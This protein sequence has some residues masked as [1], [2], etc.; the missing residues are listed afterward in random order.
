MKTYVRSTHSEYS[1]Q[2][3]FRQLLLII[4]YI[5]DSHCFYHRQSPVP[6]FFSLYHIYPL[7]ST[8]TFVSVPYCQITNRYQVLLSQ[9]YR[10]WLL[11][12]ICIGKNLFQKWIFCSAIGSKRNGSIWEMVKVRTD[13][14]C[15]DEVSF[16]EGQIIFFSIDK[17]PK[18]KQLKK[19][20]E[21]TWIFD[22]QNN[23]FVFLK[24]S[25]Y[26]FRRAIYLCI[27]F[28]IVILSVQLLFSCMLSELLN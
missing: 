27:L 25:L 16:G 9:I 15:T 8:K 1:L 14:C 22:S 21:S 12:C 18:K 20:I 28:L 11:N 4:N 17:K 3:L 7:N 10:N 23:I 26:S 6:V 13:G 5:T 24:L 19:I 2:L